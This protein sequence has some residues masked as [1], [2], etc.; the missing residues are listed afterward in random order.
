MVQVWESEWEIDF[1]EVLFWDAMV[2]CDGAQVKYMIA[3]VVCFIVCEVTKRMLPGT[4][5]KLNWL[6]RI[7]IVSVSKMVALELGCPASPPFV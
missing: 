1:R 5:G 3:L 4:P 7:S 2:T 6:S